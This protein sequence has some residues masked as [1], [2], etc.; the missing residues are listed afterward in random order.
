MAN[1]NY[2]IVSSEDDVAGIA[3]AGSVRLV[4]GSTGAQ[5]GAAIVGDNPG[6]YSGSNGITALANNNFVIA[7]R[8]DNVAGI[9]SAGSVR[10]VNGSTAVQI[11]VMIVGDNF[12]DSIG[13]S[14]IT[15]LANNNFVIASRFDDVAGLTDAGSIRLVD[16]NTGAQI[17]DVVVGSVKNDMQGVSITVPANE[18]Y[19]ILALPNADNNGSVDSGL[20]RLIAP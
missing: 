5:I 16:G 8:L 17:G 1:N 12:G 13:I 20:V 14:G 6:D 11:G 4:S 9:F 15:A 19:Y 18:N 2:V 10:L 7:S 3:N